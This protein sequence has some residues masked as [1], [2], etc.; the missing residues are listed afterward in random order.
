MPNKQALVLIISV[1]FSLSFVALAI[2]QETTPPATG[3]GG[4]GETAPTTSGETGGETTTTPTAGEGGEGGGEGVTA[5][6]PVPCPS[7]PPPIDCGTNARGVDDL[8]SRGC[9]I[10]RHCEPTVG[11]STGPATS[12]GGGGCPPAPPGI[13]CDGRV[14]DNFDSNGCL[15]GRHCRAEGETG[16]PPQTRQCPL[17]QTCP[18]G[19]RPCTLIDNRCECKPCPPPSGCR[20]EKDPSTGFVRVICEAKPEMRCPD[21]PYGADKP[22]RD[23]GGNPVWRTDPRGCN[24]I[25]CQL[26]SVNNNPFSQNRTCP[27]EEEIQRVRE[28]CTD[29]RFVIMD[30]MGCKVGICRG[31]YQQQLR[32]ECRFLPES[33]W[34]RM[35]QECNPKG[36]AAISSYDENGCQKIVCGNTNEC[37]TSL[38]EE[39]YTKCKEQGG[40]MVVKNDG[41]GCIVF[42]KCVMKG[43]DTDIYYE[44][45]TEMP[46]VTEM[47]SMAF[48]LEELKI[49][50]DQLRAKTEDVARY[51]ESVGSGEAERFKRVAG[52]F[53]SIKDKINEIKTKFRDRLETISREDIREIRHDIKYIKDKMLKDV[54]YLMLSSSDEVKDITSKSESDC[55]YDSQCFD[56]ALRVCKPVTFYPEQ[57]KES[58]VAKITGMEGTSCVLTVSA[59]AGP[60]G[61]QSMTCKYPNYAMGVR[62]PEELLPYCT[63][64]LVELMKTYGAKPPETGPTQPAQRPA[65]SETC[66][67]PPAPISCGVNERI[68]D[69]TDSS[70]C[71]ASRH[72]ESLRAGGGGVAPGTSGG[73]AG[74]ATPCSGCLNN[75]VCDPGE[76]AGCADCMGG[77]G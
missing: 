63:G 61:V 46:E 57:G 24:F 52:M 68:V 35:K 11:S 67:E 8:D 32:Q 26:N 72:C 9:I 12:S 27:R 19:S 70:G 69:V 38:P 39:A 45:V 20:E 17:D 30:D 37:R 55:G 44:D 64:P 77:G 73:G 18:D 49:Q 29:G 4:G 42:Q 51:Y 60:M 2:A 6:A 16:Q 43:D 13:Q 58:P 59:E 50:F 41:M 31:E 56:K 1:M 54:L 23:K 66:P 10:G 15:V 28:K 75:G 7:P 3:E 33:E 21:T 47:L 74:G 40:E 5:P 34:E 62:G 36:L 48:K 76:C 25:D 65:E 22:C 14:V 53:N 71:V